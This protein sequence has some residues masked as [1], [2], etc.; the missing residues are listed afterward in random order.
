MSG[1]CIRKWR[2]ASLDLLLFSKLELARIRERAVGV[3][4]FEH[5]E[6]GLELAGRIFGGTHL[7]EEDG[8]GLGG[9]MEQGDIFLEGRELAVFLQE[10]PAT[11]ATED[12]VGAGGGD[13]GLLEGRMN[14]AGAVDGANEFA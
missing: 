10:C 1:I 5:G 4:D 13:A 2:V 9:A 7:P 11:A 6:G 14:V 8:K 3:A 12:L